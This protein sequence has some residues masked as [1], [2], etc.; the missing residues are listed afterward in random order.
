MTENQTIRCFA[1]RLDEAYPKAAMH[2][3]LEACINVPW[4]EWMC[5]IG[6]VVHG[7]GDKNSK[8]AST[9]FGVSGGHTRIHQRSEIHGPIPPRVVLN[10]SALRGGG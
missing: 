2:T 1:V 9:V 4:H 8:P 3:F 7:V 6:P 5:P 10:T